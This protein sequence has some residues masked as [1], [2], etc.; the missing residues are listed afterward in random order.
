[1]RNFLNILGA[2]GMVVA[3]L[4]VGLLVY[5]R[6]YPYNWLTFSTDTFPVNKTEFVAGDTLVYTS[7]YC[8]AKDFVTDVSRAFVDDILFATPTTLANNPAGCRK[9]NVQV[10]IPN[11]PSG[12][13]HL[14]IVYVYRPNP[15]REIEIIKYTDFFNIIE[16][17]K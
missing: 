16:N 12:R 2:I 4:F 11:L 1:M 6:L 7:N 8:K 5:W 9:N 17:N 14:R 10:L 13:F 15:V 3:F